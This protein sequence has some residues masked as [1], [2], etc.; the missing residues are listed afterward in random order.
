MIYFLK[1]V[2]FVVLVKQKF[3][4]IILQILYSYNFVVS[5][6]NN[7]VLFMMNQI[8]TTRKNILISLNYVKK[9]LENIDKFDANIKKIST[10][11]DLNR[12]NKIEVN[13]LRLA[14]YEIIYEKIPFKIVVSEGIRLTKKFSSKS[15]ASFINAI[16]DKFYSDKHE[17]I[18]K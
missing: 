11:Y 2:E 3:R 4:E 16:L 8:K 1:K 7:L 14:M 15:S 10:S 12:I 18:T 6:D 13:I 17:N 9:I 5:D